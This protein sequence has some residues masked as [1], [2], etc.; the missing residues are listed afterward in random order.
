MKDCTCE[1][2]VAICE[3]R[4]CWGTPIEIAKLIELGFGNRMMLDWWADAGGDDIY[5]ICPAV[6]GYE[7]DRSPFFPVG[8][9]SM[10]E[11]DRC[12]VHQWKP[13]EGRENFGCKQAK[14]APSHEEVARTWDTEEGRKVVRLWKE[15]H[16]PQKDPN[17]AIGM[18]VD[19]LK[20]LT[21]GIENE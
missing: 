10:L 17:D 20:A 18:I 3:N 2:C 16:N 1:K 9:C 14:E 6:V 7:G 15:L 19:I 11:N 5:I 4:P 21:G 12:V 8:R 13:T